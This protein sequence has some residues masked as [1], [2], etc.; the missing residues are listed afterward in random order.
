MCN[1]NNNIQYLINLE[2]KLHGSQLIKDAAQR[3]LAIKN[4]N[5]LSTEELMLI[6][7]L[8]SVGASLFQTHLY[9]NTAPNN[10]EQLLCNYLDSALSKLPVEKSTDIVYRSDEAAIVNISNGE[11]IYKPYLTASKNLL[12]TQSPFLYVIHLS[13]TTNARCVY[14]VID[15]F[16][17]FQVEFP[18]NTRFNILKCYNVNSKTI[19]E[20]KEI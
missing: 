1:L 14:S 6:S 19:I 17:E 11:F 3:R 12:P 2:A 4:T 9:Q 13:D 10:L 7:L 8:I 18:R 16:Y 5:N 20:M 15:P